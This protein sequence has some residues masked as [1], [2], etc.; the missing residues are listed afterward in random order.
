MNGFRSN[1]PQSAIDN[2]GEEVTQVR[3][4]VFA[5]FASDQVGTAIIN[6]DGTI[7]IK[8]DFLIAD[9]L[10]AAHR[11]GFVEGLRLDIIAKKATPRGDNMEE[12]ERPAPPDATVFAEKARRI[13]FDYARARLEKTDVWAVQDFTIEK[14]YVVWFAKTLKNW[15]AM[16]STSL[17]DGMYYEVTYNG[18]AGETYLDAYKK[19]DNVC[20][21]DEDV[22]DKYE[23][24]Q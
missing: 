7:R 20:V 1:T 8:V 22:M 23:G 6:S 10:I 18:E 9:E 19:W 13:V 11:Y 5:G 12:N 24:N 21:P 17:S 3:T 15:K 4:P 16:V 14:V 2:W